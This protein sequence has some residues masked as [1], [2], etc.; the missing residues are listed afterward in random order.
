MIHVNSRIELKVSNSDRQVLVTNLD[1][2][3]QAISLNIESEEE[4]LLVSVGD[5]ICMRNNE[6]LLD[7]MER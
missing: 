1:S 3:I 2:E 5:C 6:M 7:F 4:S